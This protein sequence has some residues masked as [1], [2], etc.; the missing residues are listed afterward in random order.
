MRGEIPALL[1]EEDCSGRSE[2]GVEVKSRR[3]RCRAQRRKCTGGAGTAKKVL[4]G[5]KIP[6]Q[7]KRSEAPTLSGSEDVCVV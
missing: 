1:E 2:C 5:K 7:L 3:S 6:Q 4:G